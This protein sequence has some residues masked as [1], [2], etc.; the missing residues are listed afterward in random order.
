[1]NGPGFG[2]KAMNFGKAI[3]RHAADGFHRADD[4]VVEKRERLCNACPANKGGECELCG[5]LVN[6]KVTWR[7]EKCPMELW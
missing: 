6:L 2:R 4:D 5:C 1:M 7:S 3:V